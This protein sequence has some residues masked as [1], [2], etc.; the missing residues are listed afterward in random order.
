MSC[1]ESTFNLTDITS[2]CS[3]TTAYHLNT[4]PSNQSNKQTNNQFMVHHSKAALSLPSLLIMVV[5][6]AS[7][8]LSRNVVDKLDLLGIA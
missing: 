3:P 4:H 8:W 5:V 2:G 1:V 6:L 7:P